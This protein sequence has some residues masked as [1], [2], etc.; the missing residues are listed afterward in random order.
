MSLTLSQRL[1][2]WDNRFNEVAV[3]EQNTS[4]QL[5]QQ[6]ADSVAQEAD[7]DVLLLNG[8]MARPLDAQVIDLCASRKR[9]RY[10]LLVLVTEG[11]A[12]DPAYRIARCLQDHYERF[13]LFVSGYCKSAGTLVALGAHE[14]VIADY[15]ELG[16]LDVQ[17]SKED[18]LGATRSGL[19]V[20]SA[21]STLQMKAYEAFEYFLLETKKRSSG[22]ITTRTAIRVATDLAGSLFAPIY[23]H[24]DAM[25]VGEAGRSLEIAHRYGEILLESGQN[26]KPGALGELTSH[27]PSH[28]FIIDR[29][30]AQSLFNN[31][32]RPRPDEIALAAQLGPVARD[33][34]LGRGILS[35]LNSGLDASSSETNDVQERSRPR[36]VGSTGS[37]G[38][39][40]DPGTDADQTESTLAAGPRAASEGLPG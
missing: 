39:G 20:L 35:F 6:A 28:G 38:S 26:C 11:G 8:P 27:Y 2:A 9:R 37:D 24:V 17:M 13:S 23:E 32:R 22:L 15:G 12:A 1:P 18:E 5:I 16:P 3:P 25:H 4:E 36:A 29:F 34:I 33:P 7:S 14:L 40:G 10:V 31:V 19:T 21:L 30:Q